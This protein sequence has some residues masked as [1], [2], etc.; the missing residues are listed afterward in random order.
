VFS[1]IDGPQS[2]WTIATGINN[3][4]RIV[5]A[6]GTGGAKG[7]HGFVLNRGVLTT[8]DVPGA[9]IRLPTA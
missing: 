3:A 7:N 6:Y 1:T 2:A 4:G 8:I 5:G 9:S